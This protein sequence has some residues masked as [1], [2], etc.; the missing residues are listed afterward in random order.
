MHPEFALL[1][2]KMLI[3]EQT[4]LRTRQYG[5]C[6]QLAHLLLNQ[7]Y[8]LAAE[9]WRMVYFGRIFYVFG[10][11]KQFKRFH[12]SYFQTITAPGLQC[13]SNILFA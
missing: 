12:R 13:D 10:L 4:M 11:Y 6:R 9:F 8:L 1:L 5:I 3:Q 7:F 2:Q